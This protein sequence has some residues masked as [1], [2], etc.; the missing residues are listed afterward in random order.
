MPSQEGMNML[1][2]SWQ[3]RDKQTTVYIQPETRSFQFKA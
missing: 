1:R 2:I 3:L